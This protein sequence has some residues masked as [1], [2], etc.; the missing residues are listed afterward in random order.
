MDV[1]HPR[2]GQAPSPVHG[3]LGTGEGA[4]PPWDYVAD[5]INLF[6]KAYNW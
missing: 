5:E 3:C 1:H 6:K 2:G 4:C